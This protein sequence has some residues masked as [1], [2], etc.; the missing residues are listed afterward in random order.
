MVELGKIRAL[1]LQLAKAVAAERARAELDL[2]RLV[3]QVTPPAKPVAVGLEG[4]AKLPL[5]YDP[6]V[7]AARG[8][9]SIAVLLKFIN[10]Q[11][12]DLSNIEAYYRL[13]L[14]HLANGRYGQAKAAFERVEQT[15]PGYRDAG[16]RFQT[17]VD[18]QKALGK[19]SAFERYKL[20]GEIGRGGSTVVY[21]AKDTVLGIDVALKF[22]APTLSADAAVRKLFEE[23]AKRA[24]TLEHANIVRIHEVGM[25]VNR[26]FVSMDVVE[27]LPLAVLRGNLTIVETLRAMKQVLDALAYA[28]GRKVVH[29]GIEPGAVMR[30]PNGL[31]KVLDFGITRAI[32]GGARQ[33]N[34][35][36]A[37]E[38]K[39]PELLHGQ[40]ADERSD[41]F[42]VAAT[43]YALLAN[44]SP[45]EGEER[46]IP[47]RRLSELVT[48]LPEILVDEVMRCLAFDPAARS[49]SAYALAKPV[50][51]VL[52]AVARISGEQLAEPTAVSP[53]ESGVFQLTFKTR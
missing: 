36:G 8:G 24:Q 3:P 28:H 22:L 49:D 40:E 19:Y 31:V 50:V 53:D 30:L 20:Q 12:C 4:S 39:A 44:R 41:L 33:S 47:P 48:D 15:S 5:L 21:R 18:W 35:A 14:A 10:K 17:I 1:A 32:E 16:K 6:I 42:A 37:L 13:G 23:E 52:D 43:M 9:P 26:C 27:G 25:L 11:P 7:R 45:F 51:E 46:R 34:I 29:R 38:F 2:E